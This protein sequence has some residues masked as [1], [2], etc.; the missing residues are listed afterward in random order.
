MEV[1]I[2]SIKCLCVAAVIG[3]DAAIC[4]SAWLL[5]FRE[6]LFPQHY[7]RESTIVRVRMITRNAGNV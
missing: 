6:S 5:T 2:T 4:R 1:A 7:N 3:R